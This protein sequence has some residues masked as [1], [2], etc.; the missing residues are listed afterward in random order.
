MAETR[1]VVGASTQWPEVL[2][3]RFLDRQII[4]AGETSPHQSVV[5]EFP[6]FVSVRAKPILR[7]VMPL[8]C[9]AHGDTISVV[10]PQFLDKP[11][12]QAAKITTRCFQVPGV[13]LLVLRSPATAVLSLS[14]RVDA[15]L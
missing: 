13:G 5:I 2:A 14:P 8:V 7:V 12:V 10:G 1:V 3:I 4:D 15:W 6:V 9:E 11:V